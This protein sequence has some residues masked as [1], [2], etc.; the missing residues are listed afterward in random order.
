M[1]GAVLELHKFF[2]GYCEPNRSLLVYSFPAGQKLFFFF[3]SKLYLTL[4]NDFAAALLWSQYSL[5]VHFTQSPFLFIAMATFSGNS[6]CIRSNSPWTVFGVWLASASHSRS[7][8][9]P[10]PSTVQWVSEG[11]SSPARDRRR[12][13]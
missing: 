6:L 2:W 1:C 13:K 12:K 8:T 11:A 3:V 10:L 4:R 5:Y 9:A 7:F